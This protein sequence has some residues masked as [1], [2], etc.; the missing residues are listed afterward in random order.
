MLHL[1][2]GTLQSDTERHV[3]QPCFR[4]P[5]RF[6]LHQAKTKEAS[7]AKKD[8]RGIYLH[9]HNGRWVLGKAGD[10]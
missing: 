5:S 9:M 7:I 3:H 1:D 10:R 8:Q 4:W 6:R 2:G